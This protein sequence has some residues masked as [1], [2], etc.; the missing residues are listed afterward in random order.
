MSVRFEDISKLKK[1]DEIHVKPIAKME[2]MSPPVPDLEVLREPKKGSKF[3]ELPPELERSLLMVAEKIEEG[4]DYED[5]CTEYLYVMLRGQVPTEEQERVF[6]RTS[7]KLMVEGYYI[8]S[9]YYLKKDYRKYGE[10]KAK[11]Y[12]LDRY[13]YSARRILDEYVNLLHRLVDQ[14]GNQ[15][16]FAYIFY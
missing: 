3:V 5:L 4:K 8:T 16:I 12:A 6:I 7:A 14:D 10:Q 2:E 13:K 9:A 11:K 1:K 15:V